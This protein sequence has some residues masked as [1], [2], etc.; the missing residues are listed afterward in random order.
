MDGR[1][2]PGETARRLLDA[3]GRA[4]CPERLE[5]LAQYAAG[6]EPLAGLLASLPAW[7]PLQDFLQRVVRERSATLVY[8]DYD[9]D[10]SAST[11]MLFRWLRRQGVP[12]N[13]F[14]PSRFKHG[15]GLDLGVIAQARAQGYANLL[16]LD[17]GT[18]NLAEVAAAREHG[19][20]VAIIDHHRPGP[21][22]PPAL[23][24]NPHTAPGLPPLCTAGLVYA[25]LRRLE[26]L[27]GDPPAADLP[28]L[29]GLAVL[30][31]VVPLEPHNWA[32]AH[33]A[34]VRLPQTENVGL[35]ELAKLARLDGLTRLTGRQACFNLIPRLN[36]AGRMANARLVVELLGAAERET[37][38][39]LVF[40]LEQLNTERKGLT[41]R[42]ETQAAQQALK[43]GLPPALALYGA[44][45][46]PG[47]LGIVAARVAE[48]FGKPV[49]VLSAA[50]RGEGLLAGS[51]RA[52]SAA[53]DLLALL[54]ASSAALTSFGGHAQAAGLKLELA[55]LP[56]FRELFAAAAAEPV[57]APA[58]GLADPV[59]APELALHDLTAELERDLWLLAPFGAGWPTP[60]AV[61]RDCE[62]LRASYMGTEKT[63]MNLLVTDGR[64]QGRIAAFN[65]SH[66]VHQLQPGQRIS[67]L[68]ELEPDNWNNQMTIMLRLL[69]LS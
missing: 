60:R 62:V 23:L 55:A 41:D 69:E 50:A 30:A 2:E 3:A 16:A 13:Y 47:V 48:R 45:W 17:C 20:Q 49:V 58:G 52:G 1:R 7:Q 14:L 15:Y 19:M 44:D 39:T 9:V 5:L 31:D 24:L 26:Q 35:E 57:P 46:H 59:P 53:V 51:A 33:R 34:L 64:V 4:S 68:V 61:L 21:E 67:P 18:A 11:F 37:A 27:G 66:L 40:R 43:L 54:G 22:L 25:V 29:A 32:L 36:A 65:H 8:G 56:Q 12:C 10:G 6:G 63:H 38:R 28:E 42:I